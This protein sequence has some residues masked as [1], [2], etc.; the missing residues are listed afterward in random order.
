MSTRKTT[1]FYAVLIAVASL[2]VGMVIAS[3]WGLPQASSAQTI[4]VPAV[5]SSPLNGPIDAQTFRNIAKAQSPTVVN[6]QTTSRVRSGREMTEFFGGGDDLLRRFF[7]GQL[8]PQGRGTP[9]RPAPRDEEGN[10]AR[11]TGTGFIIDKAGFILTNN[12]VVEGADDIRVSLYGGG[13]TESYTAKVVGGDALT[14]TALIQLTEMPVA[15]LQEAKFGDSEL[16]QPGDWVMAIGNPFELGHTVTVGVISALGR[17]IGGVRG[18][19]QNMLQT[20]AAINPGNSGGPLLNVR[21]E[22]VGINTAIYTDAQRAANI[23]IGFATPINAVRDLLPQL[24][25]GKVTRGVIGVQVRRD[26]LTKEEVPA[27]GLPSPNGAVLSSIT[28][29]G[30]AAKAGLEPGD[31][32]V[33]FNGRPV[34]DSDSLVAMVVSTKPGTSVPV[35]VYRGK[36]RRSFN[37]TID[38]LDLESEAGRGARRGGDDSS[39]EAPTATGFGMEVGPITPEVARELE[40]PR[41]R[42]GAIVT[43]VDRNSAAANAGVV[44]NDIIL[45]VNGETVTNV[46]QV[47]RELQRAATNQPVFLLVWRDNSEVFITM[48]RR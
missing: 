30:P 15:A 16:M 18:R 28:P 21:G 38:E 32:I 14:D 35:T 27:F 13:R 42:G 11:G 31:V 12:H 37:I 33:E 36:Q 9:R 25:N 48:T 20:D 29:G 23:G 47:T 4:N 24:R 46:S 39:P 44:P 40:L 5:N 43:D 7:G 34:S 10:Q 19:E 41:G 6:I 1:L 45:K 26:P 2:A 3:Q 17:P 8:P 22:V